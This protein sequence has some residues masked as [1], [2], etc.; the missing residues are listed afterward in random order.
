MFST[1]FY[2]V[3]VFPLDSVKESSTVASPATPP[4]VKKPRVVAKKTTTKL[5]L[6]GDDAVPESSQETTTDLSQDFFP[7]R[8]QTCKPHSHFQSVRSLSA[9]AGWLELI[10]LVSVCTRSRS[11]VQ[12]C[13]SFVSFEESVLAGQYSSAKIEKIVQEPIRVWSGQGD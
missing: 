11:R 13:A 12:Q 7:E 3:F 9:A 10:F 8:T 1:A 5:K 6:P 4:S 2:C